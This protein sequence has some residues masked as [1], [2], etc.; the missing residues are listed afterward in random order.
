MIDVKEIRLS[1][2]LS[3]WKSEFDI[4]NKN[5]LILECENL[6][7]SKPK[8]NTDGYAYYINNGLKYNGKI[9]IEIINELD[10]VLHYGINSCIDIHREEFNEIKMDS[11]VNVVRAKNPVQKN[12]KTNGALMF[13][14]HVDLNILNKLP[15]PL[16]TFVCYIQMP[17]NLIND[18]GVLFMEDIDKKIYSILPNE[19]DI[20]IM[21]GDL[22]H[23]PNYALNSSLDRIVL[24][25]SI[26]MDFSKLNKSLI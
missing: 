2:T 6:V 19:G 7:K 22:P 20:L 8:V 5:R 26:R 13:H 18:D 9:D 12:Y 1:P 21:K 3:I 16:Y 23:V 14:N 17:N 25:G 4:R 15:P 11:W 10:K 24:A